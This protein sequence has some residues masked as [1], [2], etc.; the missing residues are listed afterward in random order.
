MRLKF[1]NLQWKVNLIKYLV[2][3]KKYLIS[4][5][6]S[7]NLSSS[8]PLFKLFKVVKVRGAT[9]VSNFEIRV[10][11]TNCITPKSLSHMF[12]PSY[13]INQYNT[14]HNDLYHLPFDIC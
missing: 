12:Q 9:H 14:W 1:G 13:L 10:Y 2:Y 5:V 3:R 6:F 4:I 11:F 8:A 7:S